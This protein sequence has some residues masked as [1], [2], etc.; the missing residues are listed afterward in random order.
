M[1][2]GIVL[3]DLLHFTMVSAV[4]LVTGPWSHAQ[5]MNA[6]GAARVEPTPPSD[7]QN[8]C[9]NNAASASDARIA[10]QSAR[11]AELETEIG[12]RLK[13]LEAKRLEVAEWLHK[14]DDALRQASDTLVAIYARMRPEAAASQLGAMDDNVAAAIL[15][16]LPARAAGVILNEM[17][18]GRAAKVTRSMV[19]PA[20]APEKKADEITEKKPR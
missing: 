18:A 20:S 17:E 8:F 9:N 7:V 2:G 4:V 19:D 15:V 13:E 5:P 10:W 3:R 1:T 12:Q 6:V 14:R 16:K 11:L